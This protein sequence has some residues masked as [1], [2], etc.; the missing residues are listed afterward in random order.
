M[1]KV[2]NPLACAIFVICVTIAGSVARQAVAAEETAILAGGCF[3][4]VESDYDHVPGVL[5]T[6]S[7][8]IGGEAPNPTY[9]SVS[10]GGS[11]YLEAVEIIFD[12]DKVS[13]AEILDIFWR[14]VDPTDDGGQ[15][16]DRGESYKT[17][18]FVTSDAQRS[19]AEAS[20]AAI[21]AS[22]LLNDPVVTPIRTATKF[23]PAEDY[24]QNYAE[25]NPLRYNFYRLSC[26]RDAKVKDLWGDQAHRGIMEH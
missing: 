3:W 20:K 5:K 8:Y 13:Y 1:R 2:I 18:I 25:I 10:A 22:G 19:T 16:C 23:Y 7:G 12:P 26:G 11:G 6:T 17:S 21:E 9:K 14:S 15:F 4:C 24:H